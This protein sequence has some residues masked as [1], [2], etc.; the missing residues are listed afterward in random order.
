MRTLSLSVLADCVDC[1]RGLRLEPSS[2]AA[3]DADGFEHR[4]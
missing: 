1:A 2:G 3:A 4:P